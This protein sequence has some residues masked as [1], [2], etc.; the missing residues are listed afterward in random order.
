M[1]P[2]RVRPLDGLPLPPRDR[3]LDHASRILVM[4]P[5]NRGDVLMTGPALRALREAR[6]DAELVLLA[7]PAGAEAA[8]LL[9]WVDRVETARVPWQDVSRRRPPDPARDLA[10]VERLRS[11]AADAALVLTSFSQ[12]AWPAGYA[13]YLAGIPVRAGHAD[14]FGGAILSH[15]VP[16]PAP[17]HQVDRNLHL[18]RALGVPVADRSLGIRVPPEAAA[19]A[20]RLLAD[21]GVREPPVLVLPGAS[22]P[23]RRYAP[24]R[25]GRAAR[26]VGERTGRPVVVV[27]GEPEAPLA[28]AVLATCPGARSLVG[29]TSIPDLAALIERSAVVLVNNS[30]GLHLADALRVPVVAAY[31][32]TDL[33][34][35]WEPR[36]APAVLL[37]APTACVPCRLIRC[38]IGTPCLDLDPDDLARAAARIAQPTP[39]PVPTPL[40]V[41]CA[42]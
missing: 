4:R 32:G 39:R 21:A 14:D 35:E 18:L 30:L 40:E 31:S 26:S 17:V 13:A 28:S 41:S 38:P 36:D 37:R 20:G 42:G 19:R 27:G 11:L 3:P 15:P 23:A 9:P 10:L 25:L 1:R 12:T 16:G 29:R 7:S 5:D 2:E 8:A 22:A 6:P 34:P 24:G 33:E